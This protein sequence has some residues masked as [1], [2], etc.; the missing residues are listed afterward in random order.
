MPP[1]KE[2]VTMWFRLRHGIHVQADKTQEPVEYTDPVSGKV[3]KKYPSR[4]FKAKEALRPGEN[5]TSDEEKLADPVAY[6]DLYTDIVPSETDL[7]ERHGES[8]FERLHGKPV[9]RSRRAVV[10]THEDTEDIL[11]ADDETG[12]DD[13]G[14]GESSMPKPTRRKRGH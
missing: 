1:V 12:E 11:A 5:L 9:K 6:F 4:I 7:A 3:F 14:H 8:K 2:K 10:Q 13:S